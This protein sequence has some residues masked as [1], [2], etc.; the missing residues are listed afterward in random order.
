MA[1]KPF[2]MALASGACAGCEVLILHYRLL[3]LE[4][5]L[6]PTMD[7]DASAGGGFHS[8]SE[9]TCNHWDSLQDGRGGTGNAFA[10]A[11]ICILV[12]SPHLVKGQVLGA[13]ED[14][15]SDRSCQAGCSLESLGV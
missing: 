11:N 4:E 7:C 2:Q 3:S 1:V 14:D 10:A 5:G 13:L 8:L 6:I 9:R 15:S 12:I